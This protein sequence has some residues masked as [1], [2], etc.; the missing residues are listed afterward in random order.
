MPKPTLL[1]A[2]GGNAISPSSRRS[3]IAAQFATTQKTLKPIAALIRNGYRRIVITHGNGPQVGAALLRSEIAAHKVYPL[4][5]DIC[6]ADIQGGMGYMIQQVLQ[7]QFNRRT[8]NAGQVQ[9][10]SLV[11]QTV[12]DPRDPAFAKPSKP[13]GPFYT[14]EEA[15][16][17]MRRKKWKMINDAGR[18]WRRL[19]PSPKP[20]DIREWRSIK[21]L[22]EKGHIVVA[23]GGGGIPV[24]LQRARAGRYHGVEAVV[25]KDLTSALLARQVGADTLLILT[26]VD[27]VYTGFGTSHAARVRR[28]RAGAL[29]RLLEAGEF[30]AGSMRPKIEAALHFL[31][32]GGKRVI[33]TSIPHTRRALQGRIGT[34]VTN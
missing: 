7:N 32:H 13:I 17:L 20:V 29:Q 16:R 15:T 5:L 2:L 31:R 12:V 34:L 18:G 11:T 24:A 4:P 1:I 10:V 14:R 9:I 21:A 23:A 3:T 30:A 26:G 27:H 22:V 28:I 25:D 6:V 33:I 19:V 8:R